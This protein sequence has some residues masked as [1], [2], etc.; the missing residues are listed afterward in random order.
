MADIKQALKEYWWVI[1]II[2]V[3]LVGLV[4]AIIIRK[5]Y[6]K[7]EHNQETEHPRDRFTR[8]FMEDVNAEAQKCIDEGYTF[9]NDTNECEG[10]PERP[11]PSKLFIK[12]KPRSFPSSYDLSAS[13]GANN[14]SDTSE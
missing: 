13:N 2:L 11:G 3:V 8:K 4:A 9:N 5:K 6:N 14:L 7:K 10:I 12:G 1:L